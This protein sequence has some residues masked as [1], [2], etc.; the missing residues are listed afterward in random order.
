MPFR[1]RN[2]PRVSIV[3]GS[4]QALLLIAGCSGTHSSQTP[5]QPASP[6]GQLAPIP[7]PQQTGSVSLSPQVAAL[8][9]EQALQLNAVASMSGGITWSVNGAVGGNAS[10]GTIDA[11]GH[12]LSP[13]VAH[14]NN[15]VI[16]A[17]LTSAADT[18]FATA[19]VSL[20]EPAQVTTTA[21]PQ[22][23]QY[24]LFLPQAAN[25]TVQFGQDTTYGLRTA[26]RPTPSNP[27]NYGG[28][29]N[30]LVAGMRGTT[31]YH[32][33]ALVTFTKCLPLPVS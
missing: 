3:A 16:R 4:L 10:V 19:V 1:L 13:T 15:V 21:N 2:A 28:A 14:S 17:A 31:T 30:S 9:S 25:V 22:V 24:S 7:T 8:S 12:Y 20:V 32:L 11:S 18:N 26:S 5:A 23:A 29:V 27:V 33:Q 6:T